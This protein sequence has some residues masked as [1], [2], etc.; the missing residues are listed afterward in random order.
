MFIHARMGSMSSILATVSTTVSAAHSTNRVAGDRRTAR[1]APVF[2]PCVLPICFFA[3]TVPIRPAFS[4]RRTAHN[5]TTRAAP[6]RSATSPAFPRF[7][8]A[9][10]Q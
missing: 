3:P 4:T 2:S 1:A 6:E 9:V 10:I 5:R 7:V 8:F